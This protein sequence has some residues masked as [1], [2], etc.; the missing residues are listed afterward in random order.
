MLFCVFCARPA[1]LAPQQPQQQQFAAVSRRQS[2]ACRAAAAAEGETCRPYIILR[3][4]YLNDADRHALLPASRGPAHDSSAVDHTAAP[5]SSSTAEHSACV[6]G[7][8]YHYCS[9][10]YYIAVLTSTSHFDIARASM[11]SVTPQT[12]LKMHPP[13]YPHTQPPS[14]P[15]SPPLRVQ[16]PQPLLLVTR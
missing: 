12:S 14:F 1:V 8:Q 2:F 3:H 13:P 5:N 9:Y 16:P 4:I 7:C 10:Y 6:V 15:A 11:Q